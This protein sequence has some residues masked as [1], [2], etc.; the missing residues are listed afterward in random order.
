LKTSIPKKQFFKFKTF[1]EASDFAKVWA[2]E[3]FTVKLKKNAEIFE[4]EILS[5]TLTESH[6][7]NSKQKQFATSE[8][9]KVQELNNSINFR[10]IKKHTSIFLKCFKCN[11]EKSAFLHLR[12]TGKLDKSAKEIIPSLYHVKKMLPV[13]I[14][15]SCQSNL[16]F[17]I[18]KDRY[19]KTSQSSFVATS[20]SKGS[21]FHISKC[22]W[23]IHVPLQSAIVFTSRDEAL[24]LGFRPCK[25]CRP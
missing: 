8:E 25:S 21:V 19:S 5:N 10:D 9:K 17:I 15:S 14:C 2:T 1:K 4:V 6:N 7:P 13:L 20:N 24:K 3:L 18:L 16:L 11:N 23:L 22:S 12:D